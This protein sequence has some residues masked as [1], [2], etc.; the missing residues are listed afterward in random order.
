MVEGSREVN[1]SLSLTVEYCP[2]GGDRLA[3]EAFVTLFVHALGQR[4]LFPLADAS[5]AT[6]SGDFNHVIRRGGATSRAEHTHRSRNSLSSQ[7][8]VRRRLRGIQSCRRPC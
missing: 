7:L 3:A 5:L 8:A 2:R 4:V 1:G 6:V